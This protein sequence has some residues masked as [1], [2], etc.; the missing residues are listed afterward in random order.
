MN[1]IEQIEQEVLLEVRNADIIVDDPASMEIASEMVLNL[2]NMKKKVVDYWADTKKRAYDAWKSITTKEKEMLD[3]ID[4][5]RDSLKRKINAY[6]TEQKRKE[7]EERRRLDEERRRKEDEERQRLAEEQRKKEEE[8]AKLEAEGKT[9]EAAQVIQEAEIIAVA[10]E[11]VYIPPEV[12]E[13]VVEKTTRTEAGTVSGKEEIQIEII[14]KKA[15]I[16]SMLKDGLLEMID[17]KE[18][19]LK[20]WLKL[21]GKES[22]PGVGIQK[23]V[24][25]SFRS[26]K[27]A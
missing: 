23:V 3:P 22:Y 14:N 5:A 20:T 16:E 12:P 24:N 19:K 25:A 1:H 8:A 11:A 6:L 27:S 7:D 4:S 17:V 9:E 2:D 15:L 26:R 21:M 10:A 18:A 13:T